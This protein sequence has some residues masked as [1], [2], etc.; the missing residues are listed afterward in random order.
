MMDEREKPDGL[1]VLLE[2]DVATHAPSQLEQ[3][4]HRPQRRIG[5]GESVR[6]R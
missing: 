4:E 1:G 6:Q 2:D 5:Y 3:M